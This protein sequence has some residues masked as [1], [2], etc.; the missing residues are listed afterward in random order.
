MML[1]LM[2]NPIYTLCSRY[3]LGISP[4]KG[5]WGVKQLGYHPKDTSLFPMMLR[6][7][8]YQ[9]HMTVLLAKLVTCWV[10]TIL[11][12]WI[13]PLQGPRRVYVCL[14]RGPVHVWYIYLLLFD[15]YGQCRYTPYITNNRPSQVLGICTT[16]QS[17]I[18]GDL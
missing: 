8:G 16:F 9:C 12:L 17:F 10:L 15:V 13:N 11:P 14:R 18:G 2:I 1:P 7:R 6:P 5:P 3:L 4:F